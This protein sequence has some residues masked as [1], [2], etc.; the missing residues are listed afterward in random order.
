MMVK[1]IIKE[2]L[3]EKQW[4]FGE[5]ANVTD[6]VEELA[7]YAYDTMTA[8]EKLDLI[9]KLPAKNPSGTFGSYFQKKCYFELKKQIRMIIKE[10]LSD[11]TVMFKEDN[12]NEVS[13]T[14]VGGEPHK[15]RTSNE[16][17]D[18]EE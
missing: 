16:A 15:E 8:K 2:K 7:M 14:S 4:T 1:D 3:R 17:N 13:K 12:K 6:T 18:S 5:I 10:E 11:A 9:W